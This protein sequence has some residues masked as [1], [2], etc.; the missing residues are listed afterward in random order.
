MCVTDRRCDTPALPVPHCT[1]VPCLPFGQNL[2][3]PLSYFVPVDETLI[4][5][6]ETRDVTGTPMDFRVPTAVRDSV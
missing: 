6:G 5:V 3:I 1:C 4:P 2:T